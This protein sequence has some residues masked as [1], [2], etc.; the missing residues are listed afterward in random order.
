MDLRAGQH[1]DEETLEKY[2]LGSLDH[3]TTKQIEEHLLVCQVCIEKARKLDNYV[4]A[5][6][7]ALKTEPK[8]AK[9]AKRGKT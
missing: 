9:A 4:Q 6:R 2:L 5:M 7:K 8:K 1:P 3:H